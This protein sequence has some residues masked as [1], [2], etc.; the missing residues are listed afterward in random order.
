MESPAKKYKTLSQIKNI[1]DIAYD[2]LFTKYIERNLKG[3]EK[4]LD[5]DGSSSISYEHD[6]GLWR[7]SEGS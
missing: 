6:Y 7:R 4:V 5:I 3:D 2:V 1:K